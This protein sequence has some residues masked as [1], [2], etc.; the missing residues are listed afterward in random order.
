[1]GASAAAED[2]ICPAPPPCKRQNP[3]PRT[4][5]RERQRESVSRAVPAPERFQS[6]FPPERFQSRFPGSPC[7]F[8]SVI[9]VGTWFGLH[10]SF[11]A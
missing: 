1:M 4:R 10:W 3:F 6:R 11:K 2:S 8:L 7:G 5:S 9:R